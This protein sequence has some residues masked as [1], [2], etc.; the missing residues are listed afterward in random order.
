MIQNKQEG[1]MIKE[2]LTFLPQSIGV[3]QIKQYLINNVENQFQVSCNYQSSQRIPI[4][5][6]Y[7][8]EEF[9]KKIK[10]FPLDQF[11]CDSLL[12]SLHP[13]YDKED[14][15]I[16]FPNLILYEDGEFKDSQKLEVTPDILNVL[17]FWSMT[18]Q[19]SV[20]LMKDL[21][22]QILN[23]LRDT[24]ILSINIDSD[25]EAWSKYILE[26]EIFNCYHFNPKHIAFDLQMRALQFTKFPHV[27]ILDKEQKV[28]VV[29]NTNIEQIK[30]ILQKKSNTNNNAQIIDQKIFQ[31]EQS[32]EPTLKYSKE[33]YKSFKEK[34]QTTV[35]QNLSAFFQEKDI[36]E[37]RLIQKKNYFKDGSKKVIDR[38][39][40]LVSIETTSQNSINKLEKEIENYLSQIFGDQNYLIVR[41][42][43]KIQEAEE[44]IVIREILNDFVS[45]YELQIIPYQWE[46]HIINWNHEK[47]SFVCD[48][49]YQQRVR[50][51]RELSLKEYQEVVNGLSLI[52]DSQEDDNSKKY[53]TN[54]IDQLQSIQTQGDKFFPLDGFYDKEDKEIIIQHSPN[55]MLVLFW[56]VPCVFII[57]KMETFYKKLQEQYGEKLRFI[58]LGIEYNKED[59]DL[60]Y[61]FKPNSEFY[62][63]KEYP[64]LARNK[65]EVNFFPFYII[66]DQNGIIR[67]KGLFHQ[68]ESKI[69]FE[70]ATHTFKEQLSEKS[71]Q[72]NQLWD[73]LLNQQIITGELGN[74]QKFQYQLTV[75][76]NLN[77]QLVA[78]C[79]HTVRQINLFQLRSFNQA[80]QFYIPIDKFSFEQRLIQAMDI[81]YPGIKCNLCGLGLN[82]NH[83]QYYNYFKN[84]FYCCECAEKKDQFNIHYQIRDNLVFIN[85]P[86]TDINE[87]KD[88][89]VYR[90]GKNIKS[91]DKQISSHRY[92]CNGCQKLNPFGQDRYIVLNDQRGCYNNEGYS[93]YCMD[94]FEKIKSK[95][96]EWKKSKKINDNFVFL[97]ITSNFGYN[98][99]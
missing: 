68:L 18:N 21:N 79:L 46:E 52:I 63:S 74:K 48:S 54:L 44:Q 23:D 40:I 24:R 25:Q 60:I 29:E 41:K 5:Q 89:D 62:Y 30:I 96:P 12:E 14:T 2:I 49:N 65:Y 95:E 1:A 19:E 82:K 69:A 27:V 86:I 90:F 8:Y 33:D 87:L 64:K 6:A 55:Q 92:S 42:A 26:L 83:A 71:I 13:F 88:I 97:R 37:L 34:I 39:K 51:D 91:P 50:F 45:Q 53:I 81:P 70:F 9:Q 22:I 11:I 57:I 3:T 59:I 85:T 61:K 35:M 78:N 43:L 84:E 36:I 56:L 47:L 77:E 72:F 4:N 58:Y 20:Q 67:Q 73:Y 66:I 75:H 80:L 28:F 7:Y 15:F 10:K 16:G 17:I 99:F 98:N 93:D 31:T 76:S 94:C 38:S 32:I